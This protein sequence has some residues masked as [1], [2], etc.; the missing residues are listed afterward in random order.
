LAPLTDEQKQQR[1]IEIEAWREEQAWAAEQ[2]R[3][4][5]EQLAA[6]AE[7]IARHEAD[8]E[9]AE[10]NRRMRLERQ[11]QIEKATNQR[12][13]ADLR[14][15][16]ARHQAWQRDVERAARTA[17]VQRQR[18]ALLTE[19]DQMANPPPENLTEI[20]Y[21]EAAE[22]SDQLGTSDFNPKLWMQKPRS[23]W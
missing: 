18:N 14:F 4:E 2:R 22:G 6:E 17:L 9:R 12:E 16:S 23:W 20:V 19:L 3:S 13:L 11:A 7:A 1:R 10:T 21:V 5:R 15:Q 8:L